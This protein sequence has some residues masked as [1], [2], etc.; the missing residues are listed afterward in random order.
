MGVMLF[1][2]ILGGLFYV[3]VGVNVKK[4][5]PGIKFKKRGERGVET[6]RAKYMRVQRQNRPAQDSVSEGHPN[7]ASASHRMG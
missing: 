6:M 4:P 3:K 5:G 1:V 7:R 2:R